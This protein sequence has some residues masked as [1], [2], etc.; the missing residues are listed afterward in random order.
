MAACCG[1]G[2]EPGD[3]KKPNCEKDFPSLEEYFGC[4]GNCYRH[5]DEAGCTGGGCKWDDDN[6][7]G[8]DGCS[9]A[10]GDL[11]CAQVEDAWG[12]M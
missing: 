5:G 8:W 9:G 10:V 1:C 7:C 2:C 6:G 4:N 12:V 11:S 3:S